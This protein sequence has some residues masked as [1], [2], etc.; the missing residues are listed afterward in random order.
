M[1][2]E[3]AT[4]LTKAYPLARQWASDETHLPLATFPATCPWDVRQV[5]DADFWPDG[6]PTL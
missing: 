6:E 4:L 3:L 5:L 2:R 1:A